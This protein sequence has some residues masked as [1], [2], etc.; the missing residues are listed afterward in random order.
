[1]S[2]TGEPGRPP[3]KVGVPLTDLGGR[4][5]CA[6]R[7]CWRP[8]ITD[9]GPAAG[10]T[11]TRRSSKPAW[12]SRFGSRR[13][14]SRKGCRRDRSARRTACSRP[15]QAI[16]CADGYITL[17]A[18]NDRLFA[19]VCELL[20]HPEWAADPEYADATRRVR[21][22]APLV[23]RIEQITATAASGPLA[24][25]VDE[26]G[27]SLRA[28]Q[29]LCGDVRRS[30]D[31]RARHGRRGGPPGARHVED[32]GI[33]NQDVRDAAGSAASCAA[34]RRTHPRSP[35]RSGV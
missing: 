5:V 9:P 24:D 35:A 16:R 11:S 34:A 3:T 28:N 26:C 8:C 23:A 21:N 19:R 25:R 22:R 20:G 13:S 15:Y 27:H 12:R 14:T 6:R 4:A 17:G 7:R 2:V 10:S 30:A 18:A 31:P 33:P 32:A 1:M 29:Q